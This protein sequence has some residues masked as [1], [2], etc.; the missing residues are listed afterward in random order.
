MKHPPDTRTARPG[1]AVLVSFDAI[2][3][4]IRCA[5]ERSAHGQAD[6]RVRTPPSDGCHVGILACVPDSECQPVVP[7]DLTDESGDQ[8]QRR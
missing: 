5:G 1:T 7:I 3:E 6:A 2:K 8:E 4:E